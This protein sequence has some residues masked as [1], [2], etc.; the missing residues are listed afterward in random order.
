MTVDRNRETQGQARAMQPCMTDEC[1]IADLI[2][3]K[4]IQLNNYVFF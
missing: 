3:G 1:I 4:K 2:A